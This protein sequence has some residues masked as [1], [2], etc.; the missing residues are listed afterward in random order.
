MKPKTDICL[1]LEG[2]Y[3]YVTGGVSSWVHELISS[4]QEFTFSLVVILPNKNFPQEAKY[5][6]P[7]NVA[8]I[9]QVYLHDYEL[10]RG[11]SGKLGKSSWQ[12]LEKFHRN[13]AGKEENYSF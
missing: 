4:L 8:E 1:L 10:P 7:Q 6:V 11:A 5:L 13:P 3:P 9:K 2:T 12:N